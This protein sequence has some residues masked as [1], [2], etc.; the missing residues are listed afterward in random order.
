MPWEAL[1]HESGALRVINKRALS[2]AAH[3]LMEVK[4]SVKEGRD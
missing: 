2:F 4:C 3:L 1:T